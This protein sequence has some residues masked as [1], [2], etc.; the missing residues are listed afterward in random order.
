M[1]RIVPG[2]AVLHHRQVH[3]DRSLLLL[4]EQDSQDASIL[5]LF[6]PQHLDLLAEDEVVE[7]LRRFLAIGLVAF[8]RVDL[9]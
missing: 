8:G 6:R 1:E 9:V 4:E 7:E 5:V 2:A 3:L